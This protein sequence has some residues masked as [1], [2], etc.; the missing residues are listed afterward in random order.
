MPPCLHSLAAVA[1]AIR[2]HE[3]VCTHAR[4]P[5]PACAHCAWRRRH[6]LRKRLLQAC[7]WAR[8]YNSCAPCPLC[9]AQAALLPQA[10]PA[11]VLLGLIIECMCTMCAG[12]GSTAPGDSRR[13]AAGPDPQGAQGAAASAGHVVPRGSGEGGAGAGAGA[14][15]RCVGCACWCR[16]CTR[17]VGRARLRRARARAACWPRTYAHMLHR[18]CTCDEG[19]ACVPAC[20]PVAFLLRLSLFNAHGMHVYHSISKAF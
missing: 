1:A 4:P 14:C 7:C 8:S 3:S 11:G 15:V 13:R 6:R 16:A 12:D 19:R 17:C 20:L 2:V 18:A 9:V 5:G 10:A